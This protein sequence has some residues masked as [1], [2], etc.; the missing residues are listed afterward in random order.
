MLGKVCSRLHWSSK[1][2]ILRHW[3]SLNC[4]SMVVHQV[5]FFWRVKHLSW[6]SVLLSNIHWILQSPEVIKHGFKKLIVDDGQTKM[7]DI[8]FEFSLCYGVLSCSTVQF[9][10]GQNSLLHLLPNVF[11][12]FAG[13]LNIRMVSKVKSLF[14]RAKTGALTLSA[15]LLT[16]FI[17]K[18]FSVLRDVASESEHQLRIVDDIQALLIKNIENVVT[19]SGCYIYS[20]LSYHAFELVEREKSITIRI[21][22]LHCFLKQ[23][24][25]FCSFWGQTLFHSRDDRLDFSHLLWCHLFSLRSLWSFLVLLFLFRK[26]IEIVLLVEVFLLKGLFFIFS[27][28]FRL[29]LTSLSNTE[30]SLA[31]RTLRNNRDSVL[32]S[33]RFDEK[34]SKLVICSAVSWKKSHKVDKVILS[35]DS[36]I[37]TLESRVTINCF[38]K[39]GT[40]SF[41]EVSAQEIFDRKL[42][43]SAV[44][45]QI[46]DILYLLMSWLLWLTLQIVNKHRV[47]DLLS[48]LRQLSEDDIDVFCL[49]EGKYWLNQIF[50]K[51]MSALSVCSFEFNCQI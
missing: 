22:S 34:A 51:Q 10:D 48:I 35:K 31:I 17:S 3:T 43:F 21:S 4:I 13:I 12:V 19:F 32:L 15:N 23:E 36:I 41:A 44:I 33:E 14:E 29:G 6:T 11:F 20:L 2:S 1:G 9:L 42:T 47:I 8:F 46:K 27:E 30:L 18:L 38:C 5:S 24:E 50:S 26:L 40:L 25:S 7:L 49:N 39:G 37:Y 16:Q 28:V 45:Q